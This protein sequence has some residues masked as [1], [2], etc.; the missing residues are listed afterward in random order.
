VVQ[1]E[2]DPTDL[3]EKTADDRGRITLGSDYAGETVKVL[4]LND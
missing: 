2:A 4:V 3:V 1:I